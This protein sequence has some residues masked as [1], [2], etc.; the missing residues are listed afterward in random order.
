MYNCN[1]YLHFPLTQIF[2]T[3][4]AVSATMDKNGAKARIVVPSVP[5]T[6]NGSA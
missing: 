2:F 1:S 4:K 6:P 3:G 5:N